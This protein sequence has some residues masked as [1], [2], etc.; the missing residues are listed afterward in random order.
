MANRIF[1]NKG[2]I[3]I[4][5]YNDILES[6]YDSKA[7]PLDFSQRQSVLRIN[8]WVQGETNGI[9]PELVDQSR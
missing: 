5:E 9:I 1:V 2:L 8:Q 7:E 4:Q 3:L 6:F